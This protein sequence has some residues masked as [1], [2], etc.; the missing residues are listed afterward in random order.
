MCHIY[1]IKPASFYRLTPDGRPIV[2]LPRRRIDC[3]HARGPD[4]RARVAALSEV[5]GDQNLELVLVVG[6]DIHVRP[7]FAEAIQANVC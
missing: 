6:G 4:V 5:L 2:A 7:D 1:E 3:G